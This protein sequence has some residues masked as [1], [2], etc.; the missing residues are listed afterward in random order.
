MT[1]R[2]TTIQF[3]QLAFALSACNVATMHSWTPSTDINLSERGYNGPETRDL[4]EEEI[5]R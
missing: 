2:Q 1:S 3:K 4:V 5:L